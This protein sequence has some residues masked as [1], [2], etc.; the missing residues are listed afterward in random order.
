MDYIKLFQ[1][2]KKD[3]DDLKQQISQ[4][5]SKIDNIKT[6]L[7]GK[8][9]LETCTKTGALIS[10]TTGWIPTIGTLVSTISGTVSAICD[11]ANT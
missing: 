7:E 5:K 4:L 8:K 1:G 3:I 6:D 2:Y 9:N 10:A 11:I